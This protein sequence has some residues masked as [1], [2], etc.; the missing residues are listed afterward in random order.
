M[1]EKL[2]NAGEVAEL[3]SVHVSW[4]REHTRQGDIP[5]ISLGRYKRYRLHAVLD[6]VEA[7]EA[8]GTRKT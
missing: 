5:H 4:V 1:N 8:A 2:L 6:W 3:L 7:R